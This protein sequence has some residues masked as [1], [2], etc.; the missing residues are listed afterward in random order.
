MLIEKYEFEKNFTYDKRHYFYRYGKCLTIYSYNHPFKGKVQISS[1][2]K[3][4]Q[5]VLYDL[6]QE[7]ILIK[8]PN[9]DKE[10]KINNLKQKI[11][12]MQ[13]K[14]KELEVSEKCIVKIYQNV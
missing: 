6:I 8:I 9:E 2:S 4:C 10:A 13:L 7:G 12:I 5:D 14:L 11:A 3:V 1:P